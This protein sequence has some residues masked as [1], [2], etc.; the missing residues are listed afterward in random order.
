MLLR[1]N[2]VTSLLTYVLTHTHTHARTQAGMAFCVLISLHFVLLFKLV[3][4]ATLTECPREMTVDVHSI[5]PGCSTQDNTCNSL[6]SAMDMLSTSPPE[7]NCTLVRLPPGTHYIT[8]PRRLT[9]GIHLRGMADNVTISCSYNRSNVME[10][11]S[12]YFS[13]P[14][15]VMFEGLNFEDCPLPI[16]INA[17]GTV[18]IHNCL[19]R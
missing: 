2:V 9:T 12:W 16:R 13:H 7:G 18:D 1:S 8:V 5:Q 14:R 17:A 15:V 19:F 10:D 4:S 11:Y 6:Q 3:H